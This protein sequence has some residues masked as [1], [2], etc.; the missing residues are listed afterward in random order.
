MIDKQAEVQNQFHSFL[1]QKNAKTNVAMQEA[2]RLVNLYR[3][4]NELG[5]D[6]V[7]T[8]NI[9]LQN[10]SSEAKSSLN[11]LVGGQEVRQYLEFLMEKNHIKEDQEEGKTQQIGWL[12]S[13]EQERNSPQN[14]NGYA[15]SPE[16]W[17]QFVAQQEQKWAQMVADLKEEHK[18]ELNRLMNQLSVALQTKQTPAQAYTPP[19]PAGQQLEPSYSEIIEEK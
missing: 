7:D 2:Q 15:V 8:Y 5:G 3:V 10:A 9:M 4:L 18:Q 6:F 1:K 13:P 12:P 17:E 16:Q 11:A 19:P 14:Q